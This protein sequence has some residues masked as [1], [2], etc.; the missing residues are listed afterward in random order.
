MSEMLPVTSEMS[1]CCI[2]DLGSMLRANMGLGAYFGVR[3]RIHFALSGTGEFVS[4]TV[5]LKL[6]CAIGSS[7]LERMGLDS[8]GLDL[9][10]CIWR[11]L[12]RTGLESRKLD[13]SKSI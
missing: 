5:A 9:I 1:A 7:G 6:K 8:G 13:D 12:E 4:S 3:S 2:Q 11:R 10:N